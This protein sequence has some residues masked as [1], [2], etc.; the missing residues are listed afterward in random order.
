MARV[1]S[2]NKYIVNLIENFRI[3]SFFSRKTEWKKERERAKTMTIQ[4]IFFALFSLRFTFGAYI[5]IECAR[6]RE[7]V[8]CSKCVILWTRHMHKH[9]HKIHLHVWNANSLEFV[10]NITSHCSMLFYS[11]YNSIRLNL[12]QYTVEHG[13][14]M[15]ND[16]RGN[17]L[18]AAW[19]N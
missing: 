16:I 13:G 5:N 3:F 8:R 2:K 9:T 6:G 19:F 14:N 17:D 15:A 12:Q 11:K 10:R 7:N 18:K 1:I 4:I